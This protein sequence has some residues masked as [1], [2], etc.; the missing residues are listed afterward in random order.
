MASD[1]PSFLTPKSARILSLFAKH[2]HDFDKLLSAHPEITAQDVQRVTEE[3]MATVFYDDLV[4]G[5]KKPKRR[6]AKSN[7]EYQIKMTLR[8]SKPPIWRRVVLPGDTTLE[9]LH[10]VIQTV[11]GWQNCHLHMF[12]IGK[13]RFSGA[14]PDGYEPEWDPDELDEAEFRLCDVIFREK[15]KFRYDYDFGDDWEH[16]LVVEKIVSD[17]EKQKG[18]GKVMCLAG[19]GACPPEDCGGIWGYYQM[20]ETLSDPDD[21]EYEDKKEWLGGDDFDPAAFDVNQVNQALDRSG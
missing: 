1:L 12:Q 18:K 14:G 8:G 10:Y 5:T 13:Q 11:M 2:G 3:L 9:D 15:T 20:L 6:T 16:Q 21:P 4:P 17:P 7:A 19:K